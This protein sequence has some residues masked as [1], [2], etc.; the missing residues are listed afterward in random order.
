MKVRNVCLD[1]DSVISSYDQGW[2]GPRTINSQPVA[3]AIIW[4]E[5][6]IM[7]HCTCPDS[8]CAMSPKGKYRLMIYSS[9]SKHFGGRRAMKRWLAKHGLDPRYLEVIKFPLM[10]PAAFVTLDDRCIRFN[11]NYKGLTEKIVNYKSWV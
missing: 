2:E 4:I 3:C 10:K 6:F 5:N 11:G 1:F 7:T 9:R 8:I